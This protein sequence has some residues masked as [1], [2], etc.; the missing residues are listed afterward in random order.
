MIGHKY[1]QTPHDP[2]RNPDRL[3]VTELE[4]NEARRLG[5]PI[6][7]FVMGDDHA[8]KKAD[9]EQDPDKLPKLT[10]FR[11]QAK[12][13]DPVS[14]AT[15]IYES[16]ASKEELATKAAIAIGRLA[17]VLKET[18]SAPARTTKEATDEKLDAVLAALGKLT[19]PD[20][21]VRE[22]IARFIDIKPEATEAELVQSVG[23]FE[24]D[25]RAL[26][27]RLAAIALV[28]NRV[29]ALK[30]DAEAALAAGD[31]DKARAAY[32]HASDAARERAAEPVR[33]T[34]QLIAAEASAHLLA[35][36]WVAADAAWAEAAAM[37]M[38]FDREAAETI[39]EDAADELATHGEV[40]ALA[41]AITSAIVRMRLLAEAA[42]VHGDHTN[43]ARLQNN[44]GIMLQTQGE[45][46]SGEEGLRLLDEGVAAFREAL[47]VRTRDDVP[48]DW[49]LTQNNLGNALQTQGQRTGGDE[50]LRLIDEAVAAYRAALTVRTRDDN[51]SD[52]ATTLN[53]LGNALGTQ[54][55]RT[56]GS[57]GL[58]LLDEAV[59]AYHEALTVRTRDDTPVKWAMTL[60]N[61][62]TALQSQGERSHDDEGLRLLDESIVAY[63][64]TLTVYTRND[65]PAGWAKT[66]NNLGAALH[67]RGKRAGGAGG[68]RLLDD[69]VT[70]YH[71]A[72]TVRTRN[73]M[74]ADWA[75][76]QENL[77][78]AYESM[79]KMDPGLA[80]AHLSDAEA[81][82]LAAL[83]VYTPEH[84]SYDYG[85]ATRSLA[86]VR[87][88]LA[89][90]DS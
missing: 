28:D 69:A 61:L 30:A 71:D 53:N 86:R 68:L 21:A 65:M 31:L 10:A 15:R 40:H 22:A 6:L 11:E 52:W 55:E 12:R 4:F 50:G 47:T 89:A 78:L 19:I 46:S 33:T 87:K 20:R 39:V 84:M 18:A 14:E 54:G 24:S 63:R 88:K 34:A 35:L 13:T 62:G 45:R 83:T 36:D 67:T 38:P 59:A 37:L 74:P 41:G 5:R 7:L 79:A 43:T 2:T 25:Y 42:R 70:A 64:E 58:R 85:T 90:L 49:A 1:G 75:V 27:A 73:N 60:N 32:R 23:Q 57:E 56:D 9:V 76:T 16:F 44:L 82:F 51:P 72:L 77:G 48:S 81:A 29:T 26:Q 80:R 66:H 8:V 17:Q 3:S